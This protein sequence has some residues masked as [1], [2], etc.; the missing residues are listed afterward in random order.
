MSG[1]DDIASG[2]AITGEGIFFYLNQNFQNTNLNLARRAWLEN[3]GA[4][5]L[6][7]T[8]NPDSSLLDSTHEMGYMIY[9]QVEVAI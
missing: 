4:L 3:I 8:P 7:K 5:V 9:N 1:M 2:S 6:T